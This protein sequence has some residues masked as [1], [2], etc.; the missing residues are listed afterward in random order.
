MR[1]LLALVSL[2]ISFAVPASAQQK[3]TV[4]QRITHQ[5]DL[6]GDAKA[7]G[8]FGVLGMK[9]DEA[10]NKSDA[11]AVA[12]LFTEDGVLEAPNGM[13]YGRRAIEK[14]LPKDEFQHWRTQNIVKTVDRKRC[15]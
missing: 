3:D 8:E 6:L 7:L 13:F 1:S 12:A 15:A 10:F 4:E 5:R 9:V 11:S 14:G 2:V